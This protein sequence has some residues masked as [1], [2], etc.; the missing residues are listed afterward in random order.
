MKIKALV[1]IEQEVELDVSVAEV[2]Q[3]ILQQPWIRAV[4]IAVAVL[5][6]IPDKGIKEMNESQR[7]LIMRSLRDQMDR[8]D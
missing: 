5:K 1:N 8:Y 4:N 7:L 6:H 2:L 3:A